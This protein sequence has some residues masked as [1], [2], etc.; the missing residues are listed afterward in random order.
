MNLYIIVFFILSVL[1]Y[2]VTKYYLV[3]T[4]YKI[5]KANDAIEAFETELNSTTADKL[6]TKHNITLKYLDVNTARQLVKK[7]GSYMQNM[8]QPNLSAR[9]CSTIDELY[10][11]YLNG[12]DEITSSEKETIDLFILNLMNDIEKF[13]KHNSNYSY[14]KYVSKWLNEISIA[15]AK[16]WLEAGMPHTL[17]TTIIMDA[18]WF[19]T[20]RRNTLIHELTHVHQREVEFDFEDLY[21]ELGYYY[22]PETIKGMESIYPL[23]RNNPDGL[24]TLWL[25]KMPVIEGGS[26]KNGAGNDAGNDAINEMSMDSTH[27]WWIGAIFNT[28]NPD[29]L[30]DVVLV[31]LQMERDHEGHFY[32]LKQK[33]TYLSTWKPF[34]KFFGN[35]PN[36]Y[37][38]NETTAKCAEYFLADILNEKYLDFVNYEGYKIYKKYFENMCNK[39][40]Q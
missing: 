20:P 8:N 25:W 30:N 24:S 3:K 38:P 11:K 17:D 34:I 10:E 39:Y 31:A 4:N 37:H 35:N 26:N 32:Y 7:N 29:S 12:F 33:P 27:Y 9:H 19:I 16:S 21:K 1:I 2:L 23:N 18:E 40:Y 15:K 36:N 22:N 28:V 13:T 14:Y 5:N 6:K